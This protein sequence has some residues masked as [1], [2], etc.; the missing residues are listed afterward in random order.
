M[1]WYL[2]S[3]DIGFVVLPFV[4]T[5]REKLNISGDWRD[6]LVFPLDHITLKKR[7]HG[8]CPER[9]SNLRSQS[10]AIRFV[11]LGKLFFRYRP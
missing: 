5:V 10:K 7:G 2:F 11:N 1:P 9:G 4:T 6:L 8:A 3:S